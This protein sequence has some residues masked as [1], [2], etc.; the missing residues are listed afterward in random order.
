M[1]KQ[2]P[3][4]RHSEVEIVVSLLLV[5]RLTLRDTGSTPGP[6]HTSLLLIGNESNDILLKQKIM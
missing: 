3:S 2:S 1:Y 4:V 5:N 6:S